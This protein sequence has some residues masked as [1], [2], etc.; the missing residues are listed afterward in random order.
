VHAVGLPFDWAFLLLA[1][2]EMLSTLQTPD[3]LDLVKSASQFAQ[4]SPLTLRDSCSVPPD[5]LR[6]RAGCGPAGP[7]P[8]LALHPTIV[9]RFLKNT[10]IAFGDNPR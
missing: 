1:G 4:D 5:L 10:A 3:V 2:G 9:W 7:A 6:S 8:T